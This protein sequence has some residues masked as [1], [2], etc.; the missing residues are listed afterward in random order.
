[1]ATKLDVLGRVINEVREEFGILCV[2]KLVL[3]FPAETVAEES[4]R[5]GLD[6][7]HSGSSFGNGLDVV[8]GGRI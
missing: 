6:W 4:D 1:M 2:S 5:R 8:E 3:T 7:R